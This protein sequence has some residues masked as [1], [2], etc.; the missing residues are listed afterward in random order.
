M[1]DWL[2]RL[3]RIRLERK[4]DFVIDVIPT[5]YPEL[6]TALGL[7]GLPR[8]KII[9]ISGASSVGKTSLVFDVISKAQ[10]D[11]LQVLYFDIDRKFEKE[12]A[13]ERKVKCDEMLVFRPDITQPLNTILA[14]R[15]FIN[16]NLVDVII[17]D[18][19][20]A[21]GDSITDVLNEL[22]KVIIGTNVTVILL[23][24]IRHCYED[25]RCYKTPH[26]LVLNKNCHI[27][28][29]MK[30]IG[31]IKESGVLIGKAVSVDI[32]KNTMFHPSSTEIEMYY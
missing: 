11:G 7:G 31:T 19:I 4:K 28:L 18:T 29:L 30:K 21:F 17:F 1:T 20:S 10:S 23:S 3:E 15:E 32:Y 16:G 27:R 22:S 9:E 25:P 12:Y 5:T 8:G 13:N 2:D 26:M 6:D 24:Q 14:I